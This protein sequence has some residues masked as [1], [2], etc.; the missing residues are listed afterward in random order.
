MLLFVNIYYHLLPPPGSKLVS[1]AGESSSDDNFAIF[2]ISASKKIHF[3]NDPKL[4]DL[5]E[6]TLNEDS[7]VLANEK[8]EA[9]KQK[10]VKWG[11]S[12]LRIFLNTICSLEL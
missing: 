9:Q 8:S 2:D 10:N 6:W 3:G 1:I 7:I 5:L 12:L 4:A 11:E